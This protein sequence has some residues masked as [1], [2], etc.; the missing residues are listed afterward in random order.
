MKTAE[1]SSWPIWKKILFRFLFI[2]FILEIAPITWLDVIPGVSSV[3]QYYGRL[4]DWLVTKANALFLHIRPE[5]VPENASGDTS[6]GWARLWTYLCIA[7]VAA[8]IWS[9]LDKKRLNYTHLN[10]WLCLFTRY[11]VILEALSYGIIKLFGQQMSFPDLHQ[12]ATPLGD[13]VPMRLPWLFIGYSKTYQFFSGAMEVLAALLLLNRRTISLGILVATGV[14]LN[15]MMLNLS[16]DIPVKIFSMQM[17]FICLFLLINER[18]WLINFFLLNKPAPEGKIY[19]FRYTK[20]WMRVGRVMLKCI[21][22]A[23]GLIFPF[24]QSFSQSA[25]RDSKTGP[26][27]NGVYAV[28][29]YSLNN[30][31]IP[32]STQD[33]LRWKDLIFENGLGSIASHDTLFRHRYNR[34]Y[35][36]YDLDSAKHLLGFKKYG[37]TKE[38]FLEFKYAI[39]DSNTIILDGL[40]GK[41]SLHVEL[42]RTNRHFQLGER[43]FHWLNENIN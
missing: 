29:R 32:L 24:Y 13:L 23:T 8:L 41:D 15:V 3:T 38:Y 28:V 26:V 22:I 43:Q 20:K 40:K 42:K 34:A 16:Y 30:Q 17:E 12:M 7:A 33:S 31:D 25:Q 1:S 14:F 5:L 9:V 35:F 18:G 19:H 27:K 2:Y 36:S 10:Y 11:Y 21:I 6:M 39:P 37:N 4:T